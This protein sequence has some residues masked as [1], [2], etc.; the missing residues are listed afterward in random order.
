MALLGDLVKTPAKFQNP[1]GTLGSPRKDIKKQP[2]EKGRGVGHNVCTVQV[3]LVV[4]EMEWMRAI[5]FALH[6]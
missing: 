6:R 3:E 5:K 2:V 4:R 1:L